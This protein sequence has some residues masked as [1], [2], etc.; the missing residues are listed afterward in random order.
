MSSSSCTTK[1]DVFISFR[2]E[3]TRET[4]TAHL[5]KALE[6]KTI[7]AYVDDRLPRGEEIWPT[8]EEAIESS[9]MSIVIFSE[10]YATS[11][12]CLEELVKIIQ[13][14]EDHGQVVIPVFY[15]TE[16]SH[17]RYQRGSFE[18]AF[19]KHERDF[20]ESES[21]REKIRKW[22]KALKKSA[23]ICGWHSKN[24]A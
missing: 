21:N 16:P 10:N 15:R 9:L 3:D 6:N 11:K 2:G 8:L 14:R 12:W 7:R 5:S 19:A 13:W 24:Y 1:Y 22:R 18:K 4:F 17:I 20:A 23:D